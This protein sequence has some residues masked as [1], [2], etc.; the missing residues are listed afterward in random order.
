MIHTLI[1]PA[2]GGG[3]T[4]SRS[5]ASTG[6]SAVSSGKRLISESKGFFP[7]SKTCD[8][9]AFAS[10]SRDSDEI[11]TLMLVNLCLSLAVWQKV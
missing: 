10:C 9:A 11:S 2:V 8:G 4:L 6:P 7:D 5:Q 3:I 1:G